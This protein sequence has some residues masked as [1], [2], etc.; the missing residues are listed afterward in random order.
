MFFTVYYNGRAPAKRGLF[1]IGD[2]IVRCL[3]MRIII[4]VSLFIACFSGY[5]AAFSFFNPGAPGEA[6]AARGGFRKELIP[7]GAFTLLAYSRVMRPGDP[8]AIYIEGDGAAWDSRTML[9][10]D[11]TP[12][13]ALVVELASADPSPNVIYLARPGQY[14]CSGASSCDAAYWSSARFS[15][16]VVSAMDRAVESLKREYGAQGV[17]LIGYSGG[18][19]IA[20]L[21]A[22]RRHDIVSLR[23]IAGNLDHRAVNAYHKVSPLAGS[24]DPIDFAA[25]VAKVP[26]RHF[27]GDKDAV[28]PTF[29]ARSFV[30]RGG[31]DPDSRIT[32]VGGAT[33]TA[34]WLDRWPELLAMPVD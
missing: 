17:S 30:E 9:S 23:T 32:V 34:G 19:A 33:H 26:Q 24:L 16:T 18:G 2:H 21:V 10:D 5:A 8:L 12:R 20:V 11:P 27:I 15:E 25:L 3:S 6:A 14:T 13:E 31:G 22:A 1:R 28:I 4:I 29:V 7:A